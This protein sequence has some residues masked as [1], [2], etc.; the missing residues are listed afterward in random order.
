MNFYLRASQFVLKQA[1]AA[2]MILIQVSEVGLLGKWWISPIF[3]EF[4]NLASLIHHVSSRYYT[5]TTDYLLRYKL[6]I[7]FVKLSLH[8]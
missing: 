7:T 3:H 6:F 4:S 2:E 1:H 8:I 5:V